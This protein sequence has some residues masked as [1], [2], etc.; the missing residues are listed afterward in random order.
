MLRRIFLIDGYVMIVVGLLLCGWPALFAAPPATPPGFKAVTVIDD[1]PPDLEILD[2]STPVMVYPAANE[3]TIFLGVALIALGVASL[4]AGY[5][6]RPTLQH[7][8]ALY[9]LAGHLFL[10]F[11]VWTLTRIWSAFAGFVVFDL[12]VWPIPALLYVLLP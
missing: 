4:A 1:I 8:A 2:G 3:T 10:G 9:F 6:M 7:K 11:A 12:M 5:S